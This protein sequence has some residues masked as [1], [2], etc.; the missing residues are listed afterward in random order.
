MRTCLICC[1]VQADFLP[2]GALPVPDGNAV[3]APLVKLASEMDLVIV[4]RDWHPKNHFSFRTQNGTQPPHCI[5]DTAGARINPKIRKAA[6]YIV[7]KGM[8]ANH[9]AYSAFVGQTLRPKHSLP[10]LLE[11][12]EIKRVYV[13]GLAMDRCVKWTALDSAASGYLTIVGLDLTRSLTAAGELETLETFKRAGVQ[14]QTVG[15]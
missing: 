1:D 15:G 4:S 12:H 2:G 10:Q 9:E 11:E 6:H 8:D 7:S 3:I 13:G 5:Q 14:V